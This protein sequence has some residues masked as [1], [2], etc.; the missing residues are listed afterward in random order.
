MLRVLMI[1]TLMLVGAPS[2]AD[3]DRDDRREAK[4]EAKEQRAER[5]EERL[6]RKAERREQKAERRQR[7]AEQREAKWERKLAKWESRTPKTKVCDPLKESSTPGLYGMCLKYCEARDVPALFAEG[8]V[9]AKKAERFAKR[10]ERVLERYNSTKT[11]ADPDMPCIS[12]EI[13]PC[14]SS[15]QASLSF[16]NDKSAQ[17]I[18]GSQDQGDFRL[19]EIG[20]NAAID[21]PE[22][23]RMQAI[24]FSEDGGATF[25]HYCANEDAS[26]TTSMMEQINDTEA[27]ICATQVQ[28]ACNM[29]Q[30]M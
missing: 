2:L 27:I 9:S 6:Q 13:C 22:Y 14:W 29:L 18:C 25:T 11:A 7:K 10:Q 15:S 24:S 23:T 12:Q 26:T 5:R 21:D 8:K 4:R 28:T 30:G 1:A 16:W 20:T 19:S 17:P 3:D